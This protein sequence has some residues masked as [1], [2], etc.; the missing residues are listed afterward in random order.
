MADQKPGGICSSELGANWID[1]GTTC[2]S[3]TLSPAHST[4]VASGA[5][6]TGPKTRLDGEKAMIG[7]HIDRI[8]KSRLGKT[9]EGQKIVEHLRRLDARDSV[10]Y[11]E[12]DGDRGHFYGTGITVNKD[13]YQD[14]C[15]TMATLVHEGSHSTWRA[16]HP[17]KEGEVESLKQAVDNEFRAQQSELAIYQWLKD[18]KKMCGPDSVLELRL[19]RLKRGTLRSVIEQREIEN[20]AGT[21]EP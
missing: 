15:K 17:P 11:G 4:H 20:R 16:E 8:A 2:L 10:A 3:R 9:P 18:D 21:T 19:E 7:D 12:T 14:V 6:A 1:G 13:F 5:V